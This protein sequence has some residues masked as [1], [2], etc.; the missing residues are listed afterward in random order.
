LISRGVGC[1]RVLRRIMAANTRSSPA[2]GC[3]RRGNFPAVA[4]WM[5][6]VRLDVL[7]GEWGSWGSCMAVR[8]PATM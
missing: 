8:L 7:E 6:G 3:Q 2:G 1:L 5:A 4:P